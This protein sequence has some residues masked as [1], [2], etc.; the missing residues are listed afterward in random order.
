MN[1]MISCRPWDISRQTSLTSIDIEDDDVRYAEDST[2]LDPLQNTPDYLMRE[3][4]LPSPKLCPKKWATFDDDEDID[5]SDD[6]LSKFA[7]GCAYLHLL[8][9]LHTYSLVL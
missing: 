9:C 8:T 1:L 7:S 4:V 3:D 6:S 2:N 5:D